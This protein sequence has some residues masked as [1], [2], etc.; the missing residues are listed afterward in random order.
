MF[1]TATAMFVLAIAV[2]AR[3]LRLHRGLLGGVHIAWVLMVRAQHLCFDVQRAI[4]GFIAHG[5]TETGTLDFYNNLSNPTHVGKSVIYITQTLVGDAFVVCPISIS[6]TPVRC[7]NERAELSAI[8]RV[9]PKSMD[10]HPPSGTRGW[11]WGWVCVLFSFQHW[12]CALT[13]HLVAGY[14]IC[15][16]LTTLTGSDAIFSGN[17]V[18]WITSFFALSLTTNV[19]A[20]SEHPSISSRSHPPKHRLPSCCCV[21]SSPRATVPISQF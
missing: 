10:P 18:P 3:P 4:D 2:S 17:L 8:H 5:R 13:T 20:T 21:R 6:S 7:A 12:N 16:V 14:G 19:I 11:H 1:A 15:V 9:Q